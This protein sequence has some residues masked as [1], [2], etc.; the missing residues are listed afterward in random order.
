ME[1]DGNTIAVV[2]LLLEDAVFANLDAD[3]RRIRRLETFNVN[4]RAHHQLPRALP[5]RPC[6]R[7][8]T[9]FT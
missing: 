3:Y 1:D 9:L 2:D 6:T 7:R 5:V 4:F 8:Q